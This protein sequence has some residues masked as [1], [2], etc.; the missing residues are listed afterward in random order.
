[1]FYVTGILHNKEKKTDE[2]VGKHRERRQNQMWVPGSKIE[3]P[4]SRDQ[5]LQEPTENQ[6]PAKEDGCQ[7]QRTS[8]PRTASL[9]HSSSQQPAGAPAES[10]AQA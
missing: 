9:L 3:V 1:M 7:V 8:P 10:S 4:G 6:I 2:K 5:G